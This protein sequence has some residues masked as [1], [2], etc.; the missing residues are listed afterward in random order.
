[1]E[2]VKLVDKLWK[3]LV[4]AYIPATN[5][6]IKPIGNDEFSIEKIDAAR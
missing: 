5:Q 4:L 1:M 2:T 6:I 3:D